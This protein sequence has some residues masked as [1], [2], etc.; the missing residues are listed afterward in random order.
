MTTNSSVE[1]NRKTKA[2]IAS[3]GIVFLSLLSGL[4]FAQSYA[5]NSAPY[6]NT[7]PEPDYGNQAPAKP[8]SEYS[9]SENNENSDSVDETGQ[10]SEIQQS[11][12]SVNN[13]S[14]VSEEEQAKIQ[15]EAREKTKETITKTV[16][17][18]IGIVKGGA[19]WLGEKL[20]EWGNKD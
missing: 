1:I 3:V 17:K 5:Y 18:S 2:I 14:G 13:N 7:V 10:S 12:N 19:S 4:F 15:K 8:Q 16:D 20:S 9:N 11:G 6:V